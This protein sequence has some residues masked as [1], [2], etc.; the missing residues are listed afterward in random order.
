[1]NRDQDATLVVKKQGSYLHLDS[2][3]TKTVLDKIINN[4]YDFAHEGTPLFFYAPK[5]GKIKI[6]STTTLSEVLDQVNEIAGSKVVVLATCNATSG[7]DP[8][9][10]YNDKGPEQPL[11]ALLNKQPAFKA[12]DNENIFDLLEGKSSYQNNKEPQG[13]A[14]KLSDVIQ[15]EKSLFDTLFSDNQLGEVNK[16]QTVCDKLT[17]APQGISIPMFDMVDVPVMA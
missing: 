9:I 2:T 12:V 1:M 15:P 5:V 4:N 11:T 3:Q 8:I 6:L 10:S 13:K 16:A 17:I 14:L 7:A